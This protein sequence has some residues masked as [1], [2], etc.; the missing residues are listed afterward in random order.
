MPSTAV[1]RTPRPHRLSVTDPITAGGAS[2][3][4]LTYRSAEGHHRVNEE[5]DEA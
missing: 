5:R 2:Y 4:D 3:A 1:G